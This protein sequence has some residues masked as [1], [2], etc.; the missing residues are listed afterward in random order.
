MQ[1][2]DHDYQDNE[3]V[4]IATFA[5]VLTAQKDRRDKNNKKLVA[6]ITKCKDVR[7]P[8]RKTVRQLVGW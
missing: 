4:S 8:V 5:R 2:N 1:Y 7:W 6:A 3:V